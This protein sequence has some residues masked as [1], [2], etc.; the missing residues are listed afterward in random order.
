MLQESHACWSINA[1]SSAMQEIS[2]GAC[3]FKEDKIGRRRHHPHQG[4]KG[5]NTQNSGIDGSDLLSVKS[6]TFLFLGATRH[7][8]H[9]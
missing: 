1:S 6:G 8:K 2:A 3:K 5:N 4:Q 9:R 7:G